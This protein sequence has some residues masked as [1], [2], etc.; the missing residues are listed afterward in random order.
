PK[1]LRA[2]KFDSAGSFPRGYEADF[3]R[4]LLTFRHQ[5]A[6]DPVSRSVVHMTPLP[7]ILP[8]AITTSSSAAN[9]GMGPRDLD[10]AA[11]LAFLGPPVEQE[12]G[13]AVADGDV[14]PITG[15]TFSEMGGQGCGKDGS[16]TPESAMSEAAAAALAAWRG[17]SVPAPSGGG[18]AGK[19]KKLSAQGNNLTKYWGAPLP[20]KKSG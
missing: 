7:D 3:Q 17:G 4:A 6:F 14:D 13:C 20:S 15:E 9:D 1:V 8:S 10:R 11:A 18:G 12:R 16:K 5:R 2:V 19:T